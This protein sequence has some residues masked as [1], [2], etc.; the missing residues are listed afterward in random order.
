MQT[1]CCC[2]CCCHCAEIEGQAQYGQE[3]LG[4]QEQI[5]QVVETSKNELKD[6]SAP[7]GYTKIKEEITTKVY[8]IPNTCNCYK[9]KNSQCICYR[10]YLNTNLKNSVCIDEQTQ[11]QEKLIKSQTMNNRLLTCSCGTTGKYDQ[12]N[13]TLTQTVA[14]SQTNNSTYRTE[15]CTC[16]P[17]VCKCKPKVC[18][19]KPKVCK[20]KPK[21]CKCKPKVEFCKCKPEF[22]KCKPDY[23]VNRKYYCP[24][25]QKLMQPIN[26]IDEKDTLKEYPKKL[27]NSSAYDGGRIANYYENEI[28]KDGKYLV[29]MALSKKIVDRE[30]TNANEEKADEYCEGHEVVINA[31]NNVEEGE[32]EMKLK[33]AETNNLVNSNNYNYY[34][35][36]EEKIPLK[37]N[38]I[39]IEVENNNVNNEIVEKVETKVEEE[40]C[41]CKQE[42]CCCCCKI[43]ICCCCCCK[44]AKTPQK[45]V[46]YC[47]NCNNHEGFYDQGNQQ[48]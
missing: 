45:I 13:K 12:K 24:Q 21:V 17:K 7:E 48:Y 31:E 2:C 1:C 15:F 16:K 35:R 14:Q 47:W 8:K 28:S 19:C 10:K 41:C 30:T 37:K 44:C 39:E 5:S 23:V 29:S 3:G 34:E 40:K 4:T 43:K 42:K 20:C 6:T 25:C 22:C 11:L 18:K 26:F 36:K 46:T 33:N 32:G 9:G 27:T 38:E